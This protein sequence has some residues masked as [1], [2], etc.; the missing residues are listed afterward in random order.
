MRGLNGYFWCRRHRA[1]GQG[2]LT[3]VPLQIT[4]LI[5]GRWRE[6]SNGR[7]GFDC[8]STGKPRCIALHYIV[9]H[10]CCVVF[11][12]LQIGRQDPPPAN[13]ITAC[14]IAVVWNWILHMSGLCLYWRRQ[15]PCG[16]IPS[17]QSAD[18]MNKKL[19]KQGPIAWFCQLSSGSP[20]S[21]GHRVLLNAVSSEGEGEG[22]EIS[23]ERD[24]GGIWEEYLCFQEHQ[25]QHKWATRNKKVTWKMLPDLIIQPSVHV[26]FLFRER[27]RE[28][29]QV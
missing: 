4:E 15:L 25:R 18:I 27:T 20:V 13:K 12:F 28:Y 3:C 19:F 14:F 17:W 1:V 8:S 16:K 6:E 29:G 23:L 24:L 21:R 7:W 2:Y 10:R 26:G 11:C 9:L 5:P 22:S